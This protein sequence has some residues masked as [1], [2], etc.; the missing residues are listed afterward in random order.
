MSA[1]DR[2]V[3]TPMSLLA[4]STSTVSIWAT[5]GGACSGSGR[6]ARNAAMAPAARAMM[7]TMIRAGFITL[8]FP[9]GH[10]SGSRG[11]NR[12]HDTA[13]GLIAPWTGFQQVNVKAWLMR[14]IQIELIDST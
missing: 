11:R 12:Q 1:G 4:T 7:R 8:H 3:P 5:G 9:R 10:T 13:I 2:A 6:L 14:G